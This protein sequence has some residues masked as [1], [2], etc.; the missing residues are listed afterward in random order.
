[1]T[2]IAA[3]AVFAATSPKAGLRFQPMQQLLFRATASKAFRAP[4]L[5]ET[6][7]AQQNVVHVRFWDPIR[8]PTFNESNPD[9]VID[10][11]R[12]QQG[13]PDLK[14]EKSTLTRWGCS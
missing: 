7:P 10:V 9:C 12:V 8:C 5:F 6:S 1:M 14:A 3:T 2:N 4:S 11:R 13:N